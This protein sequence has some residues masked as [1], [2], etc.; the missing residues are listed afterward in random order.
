MRTLTHI[1]VVALALVLS[2]GVNELA[3]QRV[4]VRAPL[5]LAG[6]QGAQD[7]GTPVEMFESSN[8]DRF[9]RRAQDFLGRQDY[10]NAIKVLQ[11][12]VEGRTTA[13]VAEPEEI[14]G[15]ATT[16]PKKKPKKNPKKDQAPGNWPIDQD[17]PAYSVFST[18]DRLY[19]PVARLCHELLASLP[20][21][22]LSLYRARFGFVAEKAHDDALARRDLPAMESVYNKFFITKHA[23]LAMHAAA[24]L[25]MD[26]GRFRAAIQTLQTLLEVYPEFCRREAGLQDVLLWVKLAIC[27]E[28]L[29]ESKSAA[30]VLEQVAARWS[31]TSVRIMVGA[32]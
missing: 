10:S 15:N 28:Q 12:I 17:N 16:D 4:R 1:L 21:Q 19:R 13:F 5:V 20:P 8:L 23:G 18:D 11:N 3:S 9:L 22:G 31:E 27:Y 2:A 25:L 26:R 14:T 29:G 24:D 7:P 6:A 32:I 30:D